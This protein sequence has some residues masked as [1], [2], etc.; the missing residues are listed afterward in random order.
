[1][2]AQNYFISEKGNIL[3]DLGNELYVGR[4]NDDELAICTKE[5][6]G[7]RMIKKVAAGIKLN[8][9][10]DLMEAVKNLKPWDL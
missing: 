4:A 7:Y 3:A 9:N 6:T 1:M 2:Q 10:R 8:S 5:P